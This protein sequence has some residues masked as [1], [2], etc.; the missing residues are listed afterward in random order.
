M[1][2]DFTSFFDFDIW[3]WNFSDSAI[4]FALHFY[5]PFTEVWKSISIEILLANNMRLSRWGL[6]ND[7]IDIKLI[8][9][10][11]VQNK[12][13]MHI[14]Q[15]PNAQVVAQTK[16]EWPTGQRF[17]ETEL[18]TRIYVLNW[19]VFYFPV[20]F[21]RTMHMTFHEIL[22]SDKWDILH[23]C[24]KWIQFLFWTSE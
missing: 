22:I 14:W 10:Q 9:N 6:Y 8:M 15:K 1:G 16:F 21:Q 24:N 4:C 3:Y 2:I 5:Y 12:W 20:P 18:K 23:I 11:M 17:P 13:T 7:H 19:F